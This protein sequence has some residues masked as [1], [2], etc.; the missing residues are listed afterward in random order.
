MIWGELE[1]EYLIPIKLLPL[2]IGFCVACKMYVKWQPILKSPSDFPF[3]QPPSGLL[4]ACTVFQPAKNTW[5]DYLGLSTGPSFPGSPHEISGWSTIHP[6]Q[7]CKATPFFICP[8]PCPSLLNNKENIFTTTS[9]HTQIEFI[10]SGSKAI[11][12]HD[13][14]HADKTIILLTKLGWGKKGGMSAAQVQKAIL[15]LFLPE[16]PVA[17]QE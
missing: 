14:P 5:R 10:P 3:R 17:F 9:T 11:R 2:S 15:L 8:Q 12:F 7:A 1:F 4:R 16:V 6:I 13:H